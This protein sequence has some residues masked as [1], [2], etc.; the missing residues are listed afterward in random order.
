MRYLATAVYL[1]LFV[2]GA[3]AQIPPRPYIPP[4]PI[5]NP[6]SRTFCRKPRR[7]RFA[8]SGHFPGSDSQALI[9]GQSSTKCFSRPAQATTSLRPRQPLRRKRS[10][11]S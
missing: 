9:S 7:F 6:R 8:G 10:D 3:L 11:S 1:L 5:L 2:T 4:A